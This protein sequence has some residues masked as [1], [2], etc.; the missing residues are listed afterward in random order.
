MQ[1]YNDI[2]NRI[3]EIIRISE[4]IRKESSNTE[5][6]INSF[7]LIRHCPIYKDYVAEFNDLLNLERT[8]YLLHKDKEGN[9]SKKNNELL[10]ECRKH[11]SQPDYLELSEIIN[12]SFRHN[13]TEL[14]EYLGYYLLKED[15]NRFIELC[16]KLSVG[17]CVVLKSLNLDEARK[18]IDSSLAINKAQGR[19]IKKHYLNG[20]DKKEPI[21][22]EEQFIVIPITDMEGAYQKKNTNQDNGFSKKKNETNDSHSNFREII[23]LGMCGQLT[24]KMVEALSELLTPPEYEELISLL[25]KNSIFSKE[26][27][28]VNDLNNKRVITDIDELVGFFA[29]KKQLELEGLKTLIPTIGLWNYNYLMDQLY[30]FGAIDGDTY[31]EHLIEK[32]LTDIQNGRK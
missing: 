31:R 8:F 13:A 26:E 7:S 23:Y 9:V 6:D 27:L 19:R 14:Y 21:N 15:Y 18:E 28:E 25:V 29:T 22:L 20:L 16:Q 4:N 10:D 3:V 32:D 2:L 5:L 12:R 17:P 1:T 30:K 11:S 24:L